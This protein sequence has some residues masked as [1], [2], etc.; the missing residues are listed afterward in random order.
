[1]VI[2]GV[3]ILERM[4]DPEHGDFTPE[5]AKYFLSFDFSPEQHA[6]YEMLSTRAAEGILSQSEAA[7]LDELLAANAL[8]T[9]LQSKAR[10]SLHPQ[11][12]AA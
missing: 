9:V 12:P 2:E 7:E 6:R 1:M 5:V 11:T 3:S 10:L 4:I 8:L